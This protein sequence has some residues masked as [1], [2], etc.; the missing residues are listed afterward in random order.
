MAPNMPGPLCARDIRSAQTAGAKPAFLGW[1]AKR[2]GISAARRVPEPR[3]DCGLAQFLL[4]LCP[5]NAI[6][7]GK[8]WQ[9]RVKLRQGG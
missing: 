7:V 4:R 9:L 5:L 2:L 8:T 1:S 3:L 6:R